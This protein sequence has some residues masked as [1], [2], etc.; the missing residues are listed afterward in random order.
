MITIDAPISFL[1]GAGVAYS[2][3]PRSAEPAG[4][5]VDRTGALL[6]GF[7]VQSVVLTPLIIFFMLRFPDWEWNY[8]FDAGNF[9][10]TQSSLGVLVFAVMVALMNLSFLAGFRAAESLVLQGKGKAVI[11]LLAATGALIGAIIVALYDQTLHVGTLAEFTAGT[12]VPAYTV[13]AFL[14]AQGLAG[15][16]LAVG[17]YWA[18]AGRIIKP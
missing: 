16:L 17:M 3:R 2:M 10:L 8:F 14:A 9:F 11:G 7:I 12:A 5:L 4:A 6:R 1:V 15:P 13:P 18:T